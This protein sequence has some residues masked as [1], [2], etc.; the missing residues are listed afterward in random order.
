[1]WNAW[2]AFLLTF[3]SPSGFSTRTEPQIPGFHYQMVVL[4]EVHAAILFNDTFD[5][6][7]VTVNTKDDPT[8][9]KQ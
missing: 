6:E 4:C 3:K 1:M 8:F 5:S 9:Q 2:Q 7:S